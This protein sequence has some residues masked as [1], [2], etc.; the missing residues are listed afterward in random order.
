MHENAIMKS[1]TFYGI[2]KVSGSVPGKMQ[3]Y[4]K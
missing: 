1:I 2:L 3:I 4:K